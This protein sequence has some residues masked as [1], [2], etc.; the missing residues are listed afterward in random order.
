MHRKIPPRQALLRALLATLA[1]C[2]LLPAAAPAQEVKPAPLTGTLTVTIGGT[3]RLQMSRKQVIARAINGNETVL[4]VGPVY[5]DPTTVLLTGLEPG[6]TRVRLIDEKGVEETFEVIVQLDVE[7]LRNLLKRAVPTANIDVI[8]G[9]N[10]TVILNGVVPRAE[11]V[12]VVLNIARSVVLG[13]DRVINHL[14]VDG[15]QQVQLCVVVAKVDRTL[16]RH[17]AFSFIEQGNHHFISSTVGGP[18]FLTNALL[19]SPAGSSATLQGNP[20]ILAGFVSNSQSFLGVLNALRI[21]GLTKILAEPRLLTVSGKP[22]S[23]LSGG[24]QAVPVPAGLGQVGVQFEEFG[25][26]LNFLPIVLGD[27]RIHLEIEPEFSALDPAAGTVIQGTTVPG[28]TTQRVHTTVDMEPG[29]T[30]VIGGLIQNEVLAGTSK[31]PV[32]G[33]IPYLGAAFSAKNF[34]EHEQELVIMV[35]PHL[36]DPMSCDQLPKYLPGLETRSPDD[37]ELFLEGILEAPRGQRAVWQGHHFVA[38]YKNSPSASQYPCGGD[39]CGGRGCA[40]GGCANGGCANGGPAG[41]GLPALPA[42][43]APPPVSGNHAVDSHPPAP[44]AEGVTPAAA[45]DPYPGDEP[46]QL[47]PIKQ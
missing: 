43:A 17:F 32:L 36:V 19:T 40:N 46:G 6:V 7:L 10:N 24:E 23:F 3:Q 4:R 11:D 28:R 33:E 13:Q 35:T 39:G 2:V 45:R 42:N 14:R 16:E 31:V 47:P 15:V 30:F 22:A 20:N 8:P 25:T 26:R 27:G 29:Q 12:E 9:A 34:T 18:G 5:G 41:D 1:T 37:Y 21:E 38:A 44:A